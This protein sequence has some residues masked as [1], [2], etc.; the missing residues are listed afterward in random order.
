MKWIIIKCKKKL[1]NKNPQVE[2]TKTEEYCFYQTV[3]SVVVKNWDLLRSK[4]PVVFQLVYYGLN[5]LS[6]EFLCLVILF[7]DMKWIIIVSN[8]KRN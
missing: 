5:Y 8:V 4:K 2:N 6:K 1:E 3:Q 7:K